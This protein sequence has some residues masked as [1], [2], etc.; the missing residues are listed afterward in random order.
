ML[1]K[2]M[3]SLLATGFVLGFGTAFAKDDPVKKAQELRQ[4]PMKLIANNFGFM[5]AM[6]KGKIDW[7]EQ[8]FALRGRELGAIGQLNLLRGYRENTYE[9]M[10]R[11]KPEVEMEFDEFSDKMREFEKALKDFGAKADAEAMKAGLND[12]GKSCKSCHKKFKSKEYQGS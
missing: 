1:Q 10:T 11:A 9:G 7:N 4:A 6:A 12:L 5:N 8:E 3:V 2:L